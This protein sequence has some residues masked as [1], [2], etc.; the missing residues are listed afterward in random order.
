[1]D[2]EVYFPKECF[3]HGH[4]MGLLDFLRGKP[5][6]AEDRRIADARVRSD[7]AAA[8]YNRKINAGADG[9]ETF[10]GYNRTLHR[11]AED[12]ATYPPEIREQCLAAM[13]RET[14]GAQPIPLRQ[15]A[16]NHV[17]RALEISAPRQAV[18]P[19]PPPPPPPPVWRRRR[20]LPLLSGRPPTASGGISRRSRNE[21]QS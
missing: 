21:R 14:A 6:P 13:R 19:P 7:A 16:A 10:G 3:L 5:A 11:L 9:F 1:L 18:A 12:I 17:K 4:P 15:L 2:Y 20:M 8:E